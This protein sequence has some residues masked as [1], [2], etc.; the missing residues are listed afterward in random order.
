MSD[1]PQ[2]ISPTGEAL[3]AE[4][5][6]ERDWT[7]TQFPIQLF[8]DRIVIKRDDA[9]AL[10]DGGLHLPENARERTMTGTVVATGPGLM[11]GDGSHMP[12]QVAVG[13]VVL[14]EQ[15]RHMIPIKV[16]GRDYHLV[17]ANDLLGKV[18]GGVK[19]KAG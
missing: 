5:P 10:T 13:D 6:P 2:L 19:V 17:N 9:E 4:L 7:K 16:E 1:G 18:V 15:F 14:F 3:K 12:M 8:N 11:K